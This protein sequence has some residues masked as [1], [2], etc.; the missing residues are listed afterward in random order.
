MDEEIILS[1]QCAC[2]VNEE[3][4]IFSNYINALFRFDLTN[5]SIEYIMSFENE[6]VLEAGLYT[7]AIFHKGKI[8]FIPCVAENIAVFTIKS[9]SVKYISL[10]NKRMN[11]P[12]NAVICNDEKILLYPICYSKIAYV[13]NL[14]KE[15]VEDIFL[16]FGIIEQYL[17]PNES[18]TIFY[19]EAFLD[20]KA[21]FSIYGSDKYISFNLK[22]Y[23]IEIYHTN[24]D[25]FIVKNNKDRLIFLSLTAD[26]ILLKTK[27]YED[28]IF[29]LPYT[30][31]KEIFHNGNNMAYG[32]FY[33]LL[34]G[35]YACVPI[36]GNPL[37]FVENG[38]LEKIEVDWSKI[39][40]KNS[41]DQPVVVLLENNSHIFLLPYQGDT[42]ISINKDDK[43]LAYHK[44]SILYNDYEKILKKYEFDKTSIKFLN[45]KKFFLGVF[46]D[47]ISDLKREAEEVKKEKLN[48][49]SCGKKIHNEIIKCE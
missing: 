9:R 1:T 19:G 15:V 49:I 33:I 16:D 31:K 39:N 43:V 22:S 11:T 20:N 30:V 8:I 12:F 26:S 42:M 28:K 23:E 40:I 4:W 21:Y 34:D 14:Q 17:P 35:R 2:I 45:E 10:K 29:Y 25:L 27:K 24:K 41:T 47:V 13:F 38:E 37:V 7:K 5:N 48:Y 18:K 36:Y 46:L 32:Q 6:D 44:M 3:I